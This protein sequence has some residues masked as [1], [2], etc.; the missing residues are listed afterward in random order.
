MEVSLPSEGAPLL[1][2]IGALVVSVYLLVREV[3]SRYKPH[4]H[5]SDGKLYDALTKDIENVEHAYDNID[6]RVRDL[7]VAVAALKATAKTQD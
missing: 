3:V 7:E 5:D 6:A 4:K 2:I 1:G